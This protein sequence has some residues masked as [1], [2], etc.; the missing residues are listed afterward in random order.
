MSSILGKRGQLLCV[1]A[2]VL[3]F[4]LT[5]SCATQEPTSLLDDPTTTVSSTA[6]RYQDIILD[7]AGTYTVVRGDTLSALS[8]RFYGNGYYFPLIMLASRDVAD[9]DRIV[10]GMRLTIPNLPVNLEDPT[11]RARLKRS[12]NDIAI[13]NS[14]R[15]RSLDA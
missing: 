5:A 6:Q 10:P 9:P 2:L 15:N 8:I 1:A 4:A 13:L 7:G 12:L 14:N 11:A 3:G